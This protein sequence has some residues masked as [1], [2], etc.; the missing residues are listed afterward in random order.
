MTGAS[1]RPAGLAAPLALLALAAV[2]VLL[3]APGADLVP[4]QVGDGP[5]WLRG[6]YGGGIDIG[7]G[8]YYALLWGAFAAYLAVLATAHRLPGRW[9]GAAIAV[10]VLGFT[11]APPLLS[12]DVFSYISYARLGAEH[13]LNPYETAPAAV[14]GDA[15][16]PYVGWRDAVSAY[17]PAFTLA[18]YPLGTIGVAPALWAL[19]ALAGLSV[20]GVAALTARLAAVRGVDPRMAAAFVGLNPLVL[21]HVVGGAHNDGLM[22]LLVMGAAAALAA[23]RE[24]AA[25]SGVVGGAAIKVSGAFA[26]PFALVGSR[27]RLPFLLGAASAAG[28]LAIATVALFGSGAVESLALVG[29]NQAHTSRYSI[30]ATISRITEVDVD[31]LR[32]V[33]LAAYALLVGWL[34]VWTARGGDWLRAAAWAAFGLLIATGW[35]LPWYL[36]WVLPLAAVARD[37][38]L[39]GLVLALTAF[40]LINRV[41][42]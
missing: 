25:G 9:L 10:L 6:I 18:S 13:G 41:P 14:P 15:A 26:A 40:Q 31:V 29:E 7:G 16:L 1:G 3:A 23:G 30:P 17:G 19:K 35:L 4:A 2:S 11:L 20:L 22:M 36:L 8:A 39:A 28:A 24:L 33:L 38:T 37:R 27:R 5:A 34:L 42:M 32:A 21:V 12:Q